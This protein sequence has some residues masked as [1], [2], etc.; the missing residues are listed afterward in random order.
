MGRIGTGLVAGAL[1]LALVGCSSSDGGGDD[2]ASASDFC[3][4]VSALEALEDGGDSQVT[5][6]DLAS[7]QDFVDAAPDEIS[8]DLQVLADLLTQLAELDEDDPDA[9]GEVFGLFFDPEVV[10]ATENVET[11]ISDECGIDIDDSSSDAE[12]D[13]DGPPGDLEGGDD[14]LSLDALDAYFESEDYSWV[15]AVSSSGISTFPGGADVSLDLSAEASS[16]DALE[17]CEAARTYLSEHAEDV[18][19]TVTLDGADAA[20]AEPGGECEA[21]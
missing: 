8:A 6:D 14:S 11:F 17:A 18:T 19:V 7:F 1:A 9:F 4:D 13:A 10:A 20:S 5:E 16:G 12:S 3:D 15:D 21:A 2:S